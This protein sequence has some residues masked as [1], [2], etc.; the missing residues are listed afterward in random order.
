MNR[1]S[2]VLAAPRPWVV[3]D[4]NA[5]RGLSGQDVAADCSFVLC[6]TLFLEAVGVE[7]S[8]RDGMLRK[9]RQFLEFPGVIDR[10]LFAR[11]WPHL[12]SREPTPRHRRAV[13]EDLIDVEVTSRLRDGVRRREDW[14]ARL[15]RGRESE[16][17]R[18]YLDSKGG[19]LRQ[20]NE[21]ADHPGHHQ[22]TSIRK[23]RSGQWSPTDWIRHPDL[24]PNFVAASS[25]ATQYR[26]RAWTRELRKFPDRTAKGRLFRVTAWYGIQRVIRRGIPD[27]KF[28]NN[29]E[30]A[31][32]AFLASYTFE[33]ATEDGGLLDCVR[34]T[35]PGVR[36]RRGIS[37]ND[38]RLA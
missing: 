10:V 14:L 31:K 8:K 37:V 34:A 33:L 35:F 19:F 5:I 36:V 1:E 6:D 12:S 13:G 11:P 4:W 32:Y 38:N 22:Q 18:A 30:D 7:P 21:F 9:L 25:D 2:A 28:S 3:V 26:N 29:L 23:L 16:E 20:C 15:V 27:E 24:V 17:F